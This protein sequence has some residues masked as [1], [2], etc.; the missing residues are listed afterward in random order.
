MSKRIPIQKELS[1]ISQ[2][3]ANLQN[4]TPFIVPD[5]YF[6]SFHQRITKIIL[7]ESTEYS[8]LLN[9]LKDQNP[10]SVPDG[11]FNNLKFELPE[12]EAPLLKIFN[13]AIFTRYAAAACLAAIIASVFY[14]GN[15]NHENQIAATPNENEAPSSPV[16]QAAIAIYLEEVDQFP[17]T[18]VVENE[19][20]TTNETLLVDINNAI[21]T[22][23]L[24]EIPDNDISS[25]MDQNGF[26][27][28]HSLN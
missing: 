9:S 15:F 17:Y 16:S 13:W 3:V 8:P 12:Q 24:Q 6:E 21:I 11:Y 25:Y 5:G 10:F 27:D 1:S 18:E 7:N 19:E 4:N 14:I 20:L 22:E 2:H 26:G 23:I 28:V